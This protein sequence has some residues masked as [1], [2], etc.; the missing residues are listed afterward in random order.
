MGN[1]DILDK[2][3]IIDDQY[4]EVLPFIKMLGREGISSIYWDGNVETKPKEPLT[5]IRLVILDMR[6]SPSSD[7]RT[8]ITNL[9]TL[10]RSA[11]SNENGPYILCVWSKHDSEYLREFKEG[12]I[13]EHSVPQP[14]LILN[15]EKNRFIKIINPQDFIP[16]EVAT[17]LAAEGKEEFEKEIISILESIG[18]DRYRETVHVEDNIIEQLGIS[19]DEKLKD[20]NSLSILLLWEYLAN[21]SVHNLVKDIACFSEPDV[22]WDNNIKTLIQHLAAANAGKSLGDTAKEY[23]INSLAAL[24]HMLPDELLNQLMKYSIDEDTFQFINN[25][26]IT[27]TLNGDIFSISKSENKKSFI[28]RKNN[29]DYKTFKKIS[30][31]EG[32]ETEPK[33]ICKELYDKYLKLVGNSNFKL[34]CE[35]KDSTNCNKPG[36]IYKT[37]DDN[38]LNDLI[39]SIFKEKEKINKDEICLIKLDISSSCDYAQDKLKRTR[40]LFG[41]KLEDKYFDEINKADDIYCIPELNVGDGKTFKIAFN[42]HYINNESKDSLLEEDKLFSFRELLLSEIKH[43]LSTYIGRIGIIN[44]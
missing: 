11:I 4:E 14:Y 23:I 41:I 18:I 43:K 13:D 37:E 16:E 36:G 39:Q 22:T 32:Y 31:V 24:N 2:V 40:M 5:G 3:L 29:I 33:N 34:L 10:L 44:L 6:F 17:T 42:F 25:P 21:K 38:L 27:K 9:Y 26:S 12:I 30:D 7:T 15:I 19:L 1:M 35:R 20:I 28:V 8:I